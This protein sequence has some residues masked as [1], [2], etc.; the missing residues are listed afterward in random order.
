MA[1]L[2]RAASQAI[3]VQRDAFSEAPASASFATYTVAGDLNEPH[4]V[5]N[6]PGPDTD[7]VLPHLY[8]HTKHC[9][10]PH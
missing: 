2:K 4:G 6:R 7:S 1:S 3:V 9:A 5:G 8:I 10:V